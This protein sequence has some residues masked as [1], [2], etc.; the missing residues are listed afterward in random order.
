MEISCN[1]MH[2]AYK[3][4]KRKSMNKIIS[5]LPKRLDKKCLAD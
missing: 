5:Y 4:G 2:V 1:F 3:D